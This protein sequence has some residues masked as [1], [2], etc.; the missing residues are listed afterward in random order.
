MSVN[1]NNNPKSSDNVRFVLKCPNAQGCFNSNP[2]VVIDIKIYQVE[3]SFSSPKNNSLDIENLNEE[4]Y[5]QYLRVNQEL[6]DLK[7]SYPNTT[8]VS[9][10]QTILENELRVIQDKLAQSQNI[11]KIVYQTTAAYESFGSA[12]NPV[13]T[14]TAADPIITQIPDPEGIINYGLFE[15]IWDSTGTFAGDYF[16]CWRW[17]P[18]GL[19]PNSIY[20]DSIYFTL[21][22]PPVS[23]LTANKPIS[24]VHFLDTKDGIPYTDFVELLNYYLPEMYKNKVN[25]GDQ[26][27]EVLSLFNRSVGQTFS[28]IRDFIQNIYTLQSPPTC[29]DQFLPSMARLGNLTLHSTDPTLWRKQIGE[30]VPNFKKKGTLNGLR[31]ALLNANID[32]LSFSPLWQVV[33]SYTYTESLY[34]VGSNEFVLSRP[35]LPLS[36]NGN[37]EVWLRKAGTLQFIQKSLDDIDIVTVGGISVLTWRGSQLSGSQDPAIPGTTDTLKVTYQVREINNQQEQDIENVIRSLPLMDTRNDELYEYPPKNWNTKLIQQNDPDFSLVVP[38]LNPFYNPV[39]FGSVRSIFP[40]SENVYNSDE[41]NGSLRQSTN[42]ADIDKDFMDLCSGSISSCFN[43]D[44]S[45]GNLSTARFA[46]AIAIINEYKPL[47]SI[48]HTLNYESSIVDYQSPAEES[49]DI[50]IGMVVDEYVIAGNAQEFFNRFMIGQDGPNQCRIGD[51]IFQLNSYLRNQ[52]GNLVLQGGG[53]ITVNAFAEKVVLYCGQVDFNTL[54]ISSDP[55]KTLLE[56]FSPSYSSYTVENAEANQI[57]II[58]YPTTRPVE[59]QSVFILSNLLKGLSNFDIEQINNFYLYDIELT[60][61]TFYLTTILDVEAGRALA[62]WKIRI[63]STGQIYN[64]YDTTPEGKIQL[65]NNGT[66]IVGMVNSYYDYTLFNQSNEAIINSINGYLTVSQYGLVT[67]NDVGFTTA[68]GFSIGNYLKINPEVD[69][70]LI[71]SLVEGFENQVIIENY[72]DGDAA[73]LTGAFYQRVIDRTVGVIKN[74]GSMVQKPSSPYLPVVFTDPA[75]PTALQDNQFINNYL[76]YVNSEYRKIIG[77][78]VIGITDYLILS[79]DPDPSWVPYTVSPS[80]VSTLIEC[81]QL[82]YIPKVVNP[83]PYQIQM[84][85]R[86]G[87]DSFYYATTPVPVSFT[88]FAKTDDL[89]F[90][91]GNKIIDIVNQTESIDMNI[92]ENK[93]NV[94]KAI[95]SSSEGNPEGAVFSSSTKAKD[96][97]SVMIELK[98]GDT[99]EDLIVKED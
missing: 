79:G 64:I 12:I 37:F 57:E 85:D 16:I 87:M 30:M 28:F 96:Q 38:I 63:N 90:V 59:L 25:S 81:Y 46:E 2:D 24:N 54:G 20:A 47:H 72:V 14:S 84:G 3:R 48:L 76:I 49:I 86:A 71:I 33:S 78:K 36:N 35:S 32:L 10:Q 99:F 41:Y 61:D 52:L 7:E 23:V 92:Y 97:I 31:Q 15:F 98:N 62:P 91:N 53:A 65:E 43:L 5:N 55:L 42:P 4:L 77:E 29:P 45:I 95:A 18:S 40:Y 60:L 1:Y 82:Q 19:L 67:V 50:I 6:C 13:W 44:V 21:L 51:S 9:P 66:L 26:T 17:I 89:I 83:S 11:G 34:Y 27:P 74:S 69:Q 39:V 73:G 93:K 70:Y 75:S 68:Y 58:G 8:T 94:S 22:Q 88:S 80:G 56:I